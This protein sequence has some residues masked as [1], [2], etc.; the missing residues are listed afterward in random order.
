MPSGFCWRHARERLGLTGRGVEQASYELADRHRRPE[1]MIHISRL[2]DFENSGVVLSADNRFSLCTI[3][4]LAI[5]EIC[6]WYDIPL[7]ETGG[8]GLS[9]AANASCGGPAHCSLARSFRSGIR[10][11]TENVTHADGGKLRKFPGRNF[12]QSPR[13]LVWIHGPRRPLEGAHVA[14]R[15]PGSH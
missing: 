2:A 7:G 13:L 6:G 1:S 3:C 14:A 8:N 15:S 4:Q 12:Q 11:A 10:T 9:R 5:N